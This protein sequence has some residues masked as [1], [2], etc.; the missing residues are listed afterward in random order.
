MGAAIECQAAS[1]EPERLVEALE[2]DPRTGLRAAQLAERRARF[3]PNTLRRQARRSAL[4]ILAHQFKGIIVW[5]LAAAAGLSIH[6]GDRV[7]A[8]AILVV[9][10]INTAIGFATEFRA[11]RSM[12]ALNRIAETRSRVRRDGQTVLVDARDLVPG[13]V[14]LLEA[15]DVVTADMRLVRA[16]N[17]EVDESVL[18]GE[19][20]PVGKQ[21]GALPAGTP[22]T[23]QT[24][25]VFK[26]TAVTEGTGEAIVVATGM[27]TE[28]GRISELAQTA[29]A[30]IS[31]LERRLDRLGQRLVWLTLGLTGFIVAAGA[32]RGRPLD[33]MLETGIALAVAAVPEGLPVVATLCLA[34]GMWR[35]ARRGALITRLSAVETLGATTVILTDKTGTLTENRM[36][37]T[38]YLLADGEVTVASAGADAAGVFRRAGAALAPSHHEPLALALRIGALCTTASLGPGDQRAGDPMELA[39]LAV[40][41]AGGLAVATL[42]RQFPE[43]AR[44]AFDAERRMMATLH[45]TPE[46]VLVAVKGAPEA[47]LAACREVATPAGA[48]PLNAEARADWARRIDQ[49]AGRGLRLLGLAM[50]IDA[51]PGA[52]PYQG[53]RLLGMVCLSDPLREDVP[54][55]IRACRAAGVRVVMMTGDLPATAA[56]IARQAGIGGPRPRVIEGRELATMDLDH[57]GAAD[58]QRLLAADVFARVAPADKLKIVALYQKSGQVVAMTGDGVNDAPALKK[59]DIGIA[60]GRRGTQVA[61]EAAQMVLT[62]DSFATIVAA[63]RQGRIIFAN[64]RKFVVY[65]MSCNVSEVLIVGLAVLAGLPTPLLPLQILFLNLVTDVFPAFALGL[66]AGEDRVMDQ[67]P[68]DPAEAIIDRGRW[69]YMGLLGMLLTLATLGAFVLALRWLERPLDQAI[70]VAFVTLALAQL[71]NVFNMR[72]PDADPWRNEVTR[73]PWVWAALALCLV[74]IGAALRVPGLAAILRLP[75][76]G[77]A[78]LG[79]AAGLSAL[80]LIGGQIVLRLARPTAARARR[81][82]VRE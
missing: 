31:P 82:P 1:L 23:E 38:G 21:T 46:G 75:D 18:T 57:P 65:L 16:S 80:P 66:G 55:A 64:I 24:N 79:L 49:A 9:L 45:A 3:G 12:E 26:G 72:A 20:L 52:D 42:R 48:V 69:L 78:G 73:N 15:G 14:V 33:Q 28:L 53:L 50:R 19:S 2:V 7:E 27:A 63:M 61:R 34:R 62:D 77:R 41:E 68:R 47:V 60:M 25:M 29:Q 74:L 11:A 70:T 10:A 71:W 8:A 36:T 13:D 17:L 51:E 81:T 22:V 37:V 76:P 5:L 58:R 40:A 35:M 54:E 30:E 32:L 56:E 6:M 4:T 59:A 67:P 44:H 43:R 39:L